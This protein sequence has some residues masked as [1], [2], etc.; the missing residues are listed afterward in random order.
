MATPPGEHEYLGGEHAVSWLT[1]D[2]ACQM[3]QATSAAIGM[4]TKLLASYSCR[5]SMATAA[6]NSKEPDL[7][8]IVATTL[9]HFDLQTTLNHYVGF[10]HSNDS[11][12]VVHR[13]AMRHN[14]PVPSGRLE[15]RIRMGLGACWGK[16]LTLHKQIL[17]WSRLLLNTSSWT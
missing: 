4:N 13:E 2:Q 5:K 1:A 9:K 10:T 14:L 17:Y 15:H 7:M 12:K 8:K 16:V 6:I 11:F 3:V